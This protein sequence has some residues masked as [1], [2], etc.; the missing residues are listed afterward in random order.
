MNLGFDC[1]GSVINAAAEY[2]GGSL[3]VPVCEH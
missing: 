2:K 1:I 3:C